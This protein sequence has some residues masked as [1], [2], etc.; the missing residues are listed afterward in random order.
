MKSNAPLLFLHVLLDCDDNRKR[1]R[2]AAGNL[3]ASDFYLNY[4]FYVVSRPISCRIA[5]A[6]AHD[7]Y[8]TIA[9]NLFCMLTFISRTESLGHYYTTC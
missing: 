4:R 3:R 5:D 9:Y 6:F 8:D 7:R 2:H 1:R